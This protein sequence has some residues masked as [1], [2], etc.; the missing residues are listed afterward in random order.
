M[1]SPVLKKRKVGEIE[2]VR[3]PN[4]LSAFHI[5]YKGSISFQQSPSECSDTSQEPSV[6]TIYDSKSTPML[7]C[8]PLHEELD[9]SM[10][11][12]SELSFDLE[13]NPFPQSDDLPHTIFVDSGS[14]HQSIHTACDGIMPVSEGRSVHKANKRLLDEPIAS[15][16]PDTRRRF[17]MQNLLQARG[18]FTWADLTT[19]SAGAPRAWLP[20]EQMT[21]LLTHTPFLDLTKC[22]QKRTFFIRPGQFWLVRGSATRVG[23]LMEVLEAPL[24][25]RRPLQLRRWL[26]C[27]AHPTGL[28]SFT[29]SAGTVVQPSSNVVMVS[30]EEMASCA[31]HRVVVQPRCYRKQGT[32]LAAL[33]DSFDPV[34]PSCLPIRCFPPLPPTHPWEKYIKSSP[35]NS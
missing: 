18:L 21:S 6:E 5:Q 31:T 17:E 33:S 29:A 2:N 16:H 34:F 4:L 35:D 3:N 7:T 23:G 8:L 22:P 26:T 20:L 12:G 32:I 9:L 19:V 25:A 15:S 10:P 13:T 30:L 27:N 11:V 1:R 14:Y 28:T 24:S